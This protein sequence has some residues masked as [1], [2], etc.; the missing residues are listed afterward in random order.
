MLFAMVGIL[1][2]ASLEILFSSQYAR[3]LWAF[4]FLDLESMYKILVMIGLYI[5]WLISTCLVFALIIRLCSIFAF[6]TVSYNSWWYY[7]MQRLRLLIGRQASIGIF[8][9]II[10]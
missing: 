3:L 10:N 1:I 9:S 4:T 5:A 6:K 7:V 8:I 2:S